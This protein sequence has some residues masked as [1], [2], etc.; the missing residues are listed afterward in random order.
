MADNGFNGTTATFA[1]NALGDGVL[2]VRYS[3]GGTMVDVSPADT[4]PMQYEAGKIDEEITIDFLGT[5]TVSFGD[6]GAI[7]ITWNDGTSDTITDMICSGINYGGNKNGAITGSA[8][9][10]R[11]PTIAS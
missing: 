11:T 2:G 6:E 3:E 9:F 1:N 8:S 10:K 5:S 7:A 4:D